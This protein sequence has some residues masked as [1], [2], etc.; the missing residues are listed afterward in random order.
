LHLDFLNL[1]ALLV[2]AMAGGR[3]AEALRYPAV[4][5][6]LVVGI[7]LGPPLLGWLSGS[8][9]AAVLAELGVLLM[10]L[11]VGMEIDR[12]ELQRASWAGLLAALGGFATP[13]VAGYLTVSW[14]GYPVPAA[15][16]IAIAL[17]V[18][19]LLTKSRILVDLKILDTRI[20]HVLM[21][22]A[23]ISDT[24]AL[25]VFAAVIG[26][27]DAGTLDTTAV[28]LVAVKAIAFFGGAVAVGRALFPPLFAWVAASQYRGRTF[29][30]T[31]VLLITVLFAEIAELSGLHAILGAFL[32][33]LFLDE[34]MGMP[35][36]VAREV[37]ALVHDMSIGF[38][39]PI[40]FVTAGFAVTFSVFRTDLALLAAVL[41]VAFVG[42]ILGTMIFYLPTGHGWRE[43]LTIGAGMNGRGAVEIIIAGIAL[44]RGII[45]NEVFSV[46]VFMAIF[47]TATVPL[48]LKWGVAWLRARGDLVRSQDERTGTLIVG[49]GPTA[50][51]LAKELGQAER[52]LLV[53]NN[54][55]N[56]ALAREEGLE[57][58]LGDVLEEGVLE[59][60]GARRVE[61]FV[62]MTPNTEVN[63]LAAQ[64]A[65]T[66]YLV[67]EAY[68]LLPGGRG[69]A[70]DQLIH[71]SEALPLFATEVEI[72]DWDRWIGRGMVDAVEE[73]A[74]PGTDVR[75]R[76]GE[77]DVE[78]L[79]LVVI[80]GE[81]R[82]LHAAAG[83]PHEGDR[84][85]GLRLRSDVGR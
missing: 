67:P 9:A 47:T 66:D 15:L 21:A 23:L 81:R 42:K 68:V 38:L 31:I 16:F 1:L 22:G 45:G 36:K 74:S 79:P 50:R 85:I 41:I 70:L 29:N 25:V 61:R 57:V 8:P 40:F 52:V 69:R 44:E 46:L 77:T 63:V 62:S 43:G 19:S 73:P 10:M 24:A 55:Q 18:T 20:A 60:A 49:A 78:W 33:G 72:S 64:L 71:E 17:G 28:G 27:I 76:A 37:N 56:C 53:D 84:T 26:L 54:R 35:R 30:T 12:R 5:G 7:C 6:E 80:R 51:R 75:S 32:A 11:H 14:L 83:S 58:F 65:R 2:A 3:I 4:L 48:G 13:F 59:E 34:R 82:L 39:A